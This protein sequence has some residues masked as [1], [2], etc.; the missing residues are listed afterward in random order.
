MRPIL[1]CA[2]LALTACGP[3]ITTTYEMVPPS[4]PQGAACA[5]QCLGT[6]SACQQRCNTEGRFCQ[7]ANFST[8]TFT[9]H[10]MFEDDDCSTNLCDNRCATQYRICHT[11]CG[12]QVIPHTMCTG[13][14]CPPPAAP[15]PASR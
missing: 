6:L 12:G 3:H 2:A 13:S 11:N 1:A 10:S 4:T 15:F 7:M 5:N 9:H 14:G 8:R